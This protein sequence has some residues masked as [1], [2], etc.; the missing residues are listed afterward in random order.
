MWCIKNMVQRYGKLDD[1][2]AGA[3]MATGNRNSV[4]GFRSHLISQ[5][6]KLIR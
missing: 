2:Q 4:N 1:T 3:K 6:F 5:L